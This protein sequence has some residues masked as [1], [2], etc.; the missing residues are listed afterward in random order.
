MRKQNNIRVL[1]LLKY[2]Y[3]D[4]LTDFRHGG[5][6]ILG[7]LVCDIDDLEAVRERKQLRRPAQPGGT[8]CGGPG[9][10]KPAVGSAA[11][12]H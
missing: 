5:F 11:G 8:L 6:R 7:D 9:Q 2:L 1:E 4:L 3:Y 12:S 10:A